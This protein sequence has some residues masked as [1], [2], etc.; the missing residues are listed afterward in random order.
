MQSGRLAKRITA[1][2]PRRPSSPP[3]SC[4]VIWFQDAVSPKSSSSLWRHDAT[5]PEPS[6]PGEVAPGHRRTSPLARSL[7]L[8]LR[9]R[10]RRYH[11]RKKTRKE[12]E[13]S[14]P[15]QS[16]AAVERSSRRPNM[17]TITAVES[18]HQWRCCLVATMTAAAPPPPPPPPGLERRGGTK[19]GACVAGDR[20]PLL[21]RHDDDSLK[22]CGLWS[23]GSH[24]V[25]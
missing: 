6:S 10:R 18:F 20:K 25:H 9:P 8:L 14:I 21:R 24:F 11:G 12:K 15:I 7:L 1:V 22:G 17:I 23:W 5:R 2:R 16:F 4:G 19:G 3:S 13:T